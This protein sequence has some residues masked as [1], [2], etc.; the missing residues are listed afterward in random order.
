M[1]RAWN[2]G[3]AVGGLA[4]LATA[5][6]AELDTIGEDIKN[7]ATRRT[8]Q[9]VKGSAESHM[10]NVQS[11]AQRCLANPVDCVRGSAESPTQDVAAPPPGSGIGSP[12]RWYVEID[13]Q[14]RGPLPIHSVEQ[15]ISSGVVNDRALV[16]KEGMQDWQP[17]GQVNEFK[18]AVR[19]GPPPLPKR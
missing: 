15:L 9:T 13:G 8:E 12:P 11:R 6:S 3:A 2:I 4:L 7:S 17:A 1:T 10:N 5:A 19:K 14:P 16:W 18:S